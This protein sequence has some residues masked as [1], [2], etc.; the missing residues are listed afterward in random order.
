[1]G[2]RHKAAERFDRSCV[3]AKVG[4]QPMIIRL[5]KRCRV[6]VDGRIRFKEHIG[7]RVW[8]T[9]IVTSVDPLRISRH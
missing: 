4:T 8:S 9:G 5:D 2:F 6:V 3:P 1:M 7:Q